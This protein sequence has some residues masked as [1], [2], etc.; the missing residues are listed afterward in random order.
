LEQFEKGYETFDVDLYMS[1][2]WEDD[3]FYTTDNGTPDD[4][5][6]D[7]I[8]RG[9]Q[10]ERAGAIRV[11]NNYTDIELNLSPRSDIEF[12]RD[13]IAMLE[14]DYEA[15]FLQ[16]PSPEDK[17]EANLCSGTMILI[18]EYR[19]NPDQVCEW[20]ILEWYDYAKE[21]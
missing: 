14:Y 12:L 13:T 15:K 17:S 8:F 3:F 4:P 5:S 1:S 18:L 6:D 20:R 16:L 11:F 7:I 9:G 10:Q 2:I 19:E 21:N